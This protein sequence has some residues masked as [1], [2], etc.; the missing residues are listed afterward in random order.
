M[1]VYLAYVGCVNL[2][3][4]GGI[5][6]IVL[7]SGFKGR[8]LSGEAI[9]LKVDSG[10]YELSPGDNKRW[11]MKEQM[12]LAPNGGIIRRVAEKMKINGK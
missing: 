6:P 9:T 5:L 1:I 7:K 4:I 10:L 8:L 12:I 11:R 3:D 2:W